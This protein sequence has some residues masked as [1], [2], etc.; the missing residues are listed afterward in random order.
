M[1]PDASD[2]LGS[3]LGLG[4]RCF[5][6][7]RFAL[8]LQRILEADPHALPLLHALAL[9]GGGQP[10]VAEANI[11][12]RSIAHFFRLSELAR[13]LGKIPSERKPFSARPA[14]ACAS[15]LASRGAQTPGFG[16]RGQKSSSNHP[17]RRHARAGRT[18]KVLLRLPPPLVPPSVFSRASGRASSLEPL[19]TRLPWMA[20]AAIGIIAIL[21]VR[22]PRP[23]AATVTD[24]QRE[25]VTLCAR[26]VRRARRA[27]EMPCPQHLSR[28]SWNRSLAKQ[29]VSRQSGPNWRA[30]RTAS[31]CGRIGLAPVQRLR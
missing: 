22:R 4:R 2:W 29:S 8:A 10:H 14:H 12:N 6:A 23:S 5:R 16:R 18:P 28:S 9:E 27:R 7:R 31:S 1:R 19:V 13:T 11:P 21:R 24:V 3:G 20:R 17:E 15:P 25:R 30:R 26:G